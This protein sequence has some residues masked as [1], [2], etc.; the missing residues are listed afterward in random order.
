[1]YFLKAKSDVFEAFK[2]WKILVENQMERKIKYF[3]QTMAWSFAM[4]S[5]MNS[6]RF[7]GS[8]DIGLSGIPHSRMEL[9]RE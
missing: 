5:L 8:Q 4:K 7:M 9:P 2:E 6:A 3:A 1:M